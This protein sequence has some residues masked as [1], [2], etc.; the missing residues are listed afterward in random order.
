MPIKIL[1]LLIS[2]VAVSFL[3]VVFGMFAI[4]HGQ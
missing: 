1:Y 4:G 3:V 2:L